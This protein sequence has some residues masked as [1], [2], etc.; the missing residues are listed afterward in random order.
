MDKAGCAGPPRISLGCSLT[1]Y[2]WDL[3]PQDSSCCLVVPCSVWCPQTCPTQGATVWGCRDPCDS[4]VISVQH[5]FMWS[6]CTL[7]P[8][9]SNVRTFGRGNVRTSETSEAEM[10]SVN[11]RDLGGPPTSTPM[12][13]W[14]SLSDLYV[15]ITNHPKYGPF[16]Y[17][18][19][20][21]MGS[22][23]PSS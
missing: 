3:F 11:G 13:T 14:K 7:R 18:N 12:Y 23:C 4:W 20:G 9:A 8:Q 2:F 15:W 21:Q 16:G 6:M 19:K 22:N 17:Q 10:G 1:C 5:Q